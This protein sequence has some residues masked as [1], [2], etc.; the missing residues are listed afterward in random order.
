MPCVERL[1]LAARAL[2]DVVH[3]V[4]ADAPHRRERRAAHHQHAAVVPGPRQRRHE[5]LQVGQAAVR[6]VQ[7][8]QRDVAAVHPADA[9]QA[10]PCEPNSGLSTSDRPAALSR[11]TSRCAAAADSMA[12]VGGVGTPAACSSTLVMDLSTLRS[13]ARASL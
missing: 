12:Q 8:R 13:M 11:V 4:L 9:L 6:A 5:A 10:L 1:R 7:R 2:R 3:P